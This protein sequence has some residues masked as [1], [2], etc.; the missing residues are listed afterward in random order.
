MLPVGSKFS[1]FPAANP[2]LPIDLIGLQGGINVRTTLVNPV[3]E[4]A[5]GLIEVVSISCTEV[6]TVALEVE[7]INGAAPVTAANFDELIA[8]YLLAH[9]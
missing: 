1:E 6:T 4:D 8:A 3:C 2:S 9:P 5:D 7:T